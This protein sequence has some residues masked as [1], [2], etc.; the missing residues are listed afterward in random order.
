MIFSVLFRASNHKIGGMKNLTDLTFK[1]FRSDTRFHANPGYL[2]P[3]LN[4][5][6]Y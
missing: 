1:A 6:G 3:A 5:A 4:N 2:K